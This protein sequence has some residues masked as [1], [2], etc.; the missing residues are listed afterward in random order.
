MEVTEDELLEATKRM[1]SRDVTPGPDG[2]PGRAWAELM[3]IMA[4]R[5]RPLLTRC[6]KEG[7]YPRAWRMAKLVLL[8][9]EGRPL[10]S[11]AA[12][13]PVCP[14]D[15]VGKL[16]EKIIATRLEAH[17]SQRVSGW[18]NSQ[19]GFRRG[20]F[21]VDAV[22]C[23]RAMAEAMVSQNGVALAV[24]LDITNAFNTIPWDVVIEVPP[25]LIRVIRAYLSDRWITYRNN[26]EEEARR[27]VERGVSQSSVLGPILWITAYDSVLRCP[28]PPGTGIVCYA[29]D[30]LI[31][32][33]GRW[34]YETLKLSE[35]VVACAV[36][37]F[38]ELGLSVS[39]AKSEAMWFFDQHRRGVPPLGLCVNIC[40]EKVQV[41][42]QM[43]YLGLTNQWMFGPHYEL[44]VPKVTNTLCGQRLM[45]PIAKHW[46]GW[47]RSSSTIRVSDSI[48]DAGPSVG[49]RSTEESSQ[50]TATEEV[51]EDYLHPNS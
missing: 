40:G 8:K 36:R 16:L 41:G 20:R 7:V 14:L 32:A 4:P 29:D 49:V 1:A 38:Q 28:Q 26:R 35:V 13:R 21:T 46:R 15:E 39:P 45:R 3:N 17:L 30:T 51:A 10:D 33:Q 42:L 43:K 22:N 34:F 9:K 37:A 50:L 18:H 31:L 25:Y 44:L 24:S 19:Y 48:Q 5:L 11:T 23:V 12:Y 47:S 27:S 2:I 6:L